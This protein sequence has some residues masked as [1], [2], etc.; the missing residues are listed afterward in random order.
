LH[1]LAKEVASLD[2]DVYSD[3]S[4]NETSGRLQRECAHRFLTC[5]L[6]VELLAAGVQDYFAVPDFAARDTIFIGVPDHVTS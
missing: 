6:L 3:N 2:D 1:R 5:P 4:K